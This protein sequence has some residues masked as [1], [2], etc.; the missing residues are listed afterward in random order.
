MAKVVECIPNF[1]EGRRKEVVDEIVAEITKVSG[2]KLLDRE[3]DKDHNRSVITFIGSPEGVLETAFN[4]V[5]R[6]SELID[7][8]RHKGEHPRLGAT[9]VVP[10]VPISGITMKE[11]VG[12]AES[13]GKR[14]SEELSI[15]VYLYE[16]AARSEGRRNLEKIRKG[17]FEGLKE[18]IRNPERHPDFGEPK[19]HPTA[20]AIVIGARYPLIA[21]NVNLGIQ[22]VNIAKAIAKAV[23]FSGG[24]FRFVKALGFEIKEKGIVQ[25]SMNLTN[26]EKTSIF[27]AF[28]LV[29]REAERYGVP[30]VG[31]EIV[32]LVPLNAVVDAAKYFLRLDDFKTEQ[33][34][35]TKLEGRE[36]LDDFLAELSSG[37]PT[38]GGGSVAALSGTL[39][40]SLVS[41]VCQLTIGKKKY[42]TNWKRMEEILKKVL[43]IREYMHRAIEEDAEAFINV[44]LAYKS[45]DESKIEQSLKVAATVPL[46]VAEKSTEG[47]SLAESCVK[48]GNVNAITD[49]ISAGLQFEAARKGAEYNVLVNLLSIKDKEFR[50]KAKA[51]LKKVEKESRKIKQRIDAIASDRFKK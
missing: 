18:S 42:E 43:S 32:G 41:M 38:P 6:A 27:R 1:S 26:Y 37:K 34:L 47:I 9:D 4:S 21:Y 14:V 48:F 7:L 31:S 5:K 45:K 29:K 50:K 30:V 12:L 33:I 39:G 46:K 36:G 17:E 10:F 51:S 19:V 40:A 35:E 16:E 8:N 11:C 15:P 49:A 25:V 3:M 24:G 28:D 20:G 23:R 13:L 44:T 22:D 2:V